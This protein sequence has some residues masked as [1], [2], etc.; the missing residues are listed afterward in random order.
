MLLLVFGAPVLAQPNKASEPAHMEYLEN[1][2]VKLGVD[3]RLG[4]AVTVLIDKQRDGRNLINSH[5]WGRQVQ[6]SFYS[7]PKPFIPPSGKQP[8]ERW[9]ELGWNPIQ[10]GD[11]GGNRS[12]VLESRNDGESIYAKCVPMQWPHRNVPC[13]C[14]FECTYRLNGNAVEATCAINNDRPD[15]TQYQGRSQ[16][17]PAVYTNGPWYKLVTYIGD[18]PFAGQPL[19]V[20]VN[21]GDER[22]WPWLHFYA[23]EHW[24]A[25]VDEDDFGLGVYQ[26]ISSDFLGGFHGGD[27]SKGAGGEKDVQT[28][29]ISPL[30]QE[31]LDHNIRYEYEY[32]LVVGSLDEIRQYAYT[33]NIKRGNAQLPRYIFESDRSQWIYHDTTD[34]GWPIEGELAVSLNPTSPSEWTGPRTF[35]SAENAPGLEVEAAFDPAANESAPLTIIVELEPFAPNDLEHSLHWGGPPEQ[36]PPRL[37]IPWA[38]PGDGKFHTVEFDLREID[39][40]Q[41]GMTRVRLTVPQG[42]GMLRARRIEFLAEPQNEF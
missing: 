41:G 42:T 13:E 16:E 26:P 23:P 22:G 5:D 14:T 1:E 18:Q 34:E 7:G 3:L 33:Q 12:E 17:L 36:G 8:T 39:G 25:L 9:A 11:V 19:S 32:A 4:G 15:N 35:W 38:L 20:L 10:S 31:I 30:S 27:D 29:Y 2:Y 28:G 40:Y 24:T 6:M 37:R 21:K